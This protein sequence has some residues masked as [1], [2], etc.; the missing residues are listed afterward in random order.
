MAKN[1]DI[2]ARVHSLG[3]LA[4]DE[5]MDIKDNLRGQYRALLI[6]YDVDNWEDIPDEEVRKLGGQLE[7]LM[8]A[9]TFRAESLSRWLDKMEEMDLTGF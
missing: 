1:S 6:S 2:L 9:I 4:F 3:S 8:I 7:D 5:L